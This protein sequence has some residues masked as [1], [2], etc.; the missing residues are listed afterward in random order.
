MSND[1]YDI[2]KHSQPVIFV[3][4]SAE[5]QERFLS[6]SVKALNVSWVD[7]LEFDPSISG[8]KELRPLISGLEMK[9][10][11][12]K[13][14]LLVI[15]NADNMND[16][17][18]NTL[19]KTLEEPPHYGRIIIFAKNLSK[20]LPTIRSRCHR[21][22]FESGKDAPETGGINFDLNFSQFLKELN[23]IENKGVPDTLELIFMRERGKLAEGKLEYF[24]FYK[25][26]AE[27]YVS[28]KNTNV[29]RK[30]LLENLWVMHKK[31]GK[32]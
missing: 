20:L 7:I 28:S 16:E 22:F 14:R 5:L 18:A 6:D 19:L 9:P 13:W 32:K 31:L 15:K 3:S 10:H 21:V 26:V 1:F 17:Q 24:Q 2:K 25:R 11:S 30:L 23:L 8:V 12:S 27:S 4:S 29:N